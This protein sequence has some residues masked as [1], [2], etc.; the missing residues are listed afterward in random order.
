MKIIS[1]L[2]ILAFGDAVGND[3]IAVHNSLKKAGYDSMI[4]ASVIDGRLGDGIATSADDL[5]FIKSEDIVI[6]HLSTGHELNWRFAKLDCHKIIKYHNI[7]PPEFFFGYNTQALVNC[8]EGYRALHAL[9][10]QA[11]FCFAD[12]DYNKQELIKAGYRCPIDV[13]PILIPFDDYKKEPDAEVRQ[14]M[15]EDGYTNILFTGR[16][17]PNKRQEDVIATFYHY[18]KYYNPKSRLILIGNY[19][20]MESYYESLQRYIDELGAENIIFPG[21]ISF[22]AI[23]AYYA[24]ADLFLCMSDHEGFCVPLVEAMNFEVPVL[25]KNTTAIP[26]TLGGSGMMLEDNDPLVAA[27]AINRI[28][29]DTQLRETIIA[30]QNERLQDFSHDRI[31][32]QLLC[33]IKKFIDNMN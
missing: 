19:T 13:L 2:P 25:A 16:I 30:N 17:V 8:M 1:M 14:K 6:F 28:L 7:T 32:Q 18:H 10:K 27:T 24:T 12:S 29:T 23:L 26:Y 11:E 9:A 3:T 31:E 21:H 20:G 33:E 4:V 22:P 15:T 5:S